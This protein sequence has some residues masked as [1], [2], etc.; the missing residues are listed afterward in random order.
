M[1]KDAY[2]FAVPPIIAGVACLFLGWNIPGAIRFSLAA[3][4]FIFSA[5]PS[6]RFQQIPAAIVSPADGKVVDIVSEEFESRTGTRISIFLS[7]WN[8]H[9]QRAPVAGKITRSDVSSGT[10]LWRLSR[11]GFR[12]KR[13]K[14]NLY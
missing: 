12:R 6:A 13:A 7:I 5:I 14:P 4:S 9:V 3:L 10:L 1:V 2:K 8:V 11:P